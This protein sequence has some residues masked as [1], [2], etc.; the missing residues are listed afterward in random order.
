MERKHVRIW[1]DAEGDY[2]EVTFERRESYF[3]ERTRTTA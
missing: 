1:Y 2:L 3:R